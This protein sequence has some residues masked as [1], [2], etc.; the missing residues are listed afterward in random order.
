MTATTGSLLATDLDGTLLRSD[1]TVSARTRQHLD[2]AASAGIDLVFVTGRPIHFLDGIAEAT[3]HNGLVLCANGAMVA[4]LDTLTPLLVRTMA[5]DD[6]RQIATTLADL[7]AQAEFR[8]MMH[9]EGE[10]PLRV[11]DRGKV[12]ERKLHDLLGDGWL[13]YKMAVISGREDDT[14]DEYLAQIVPHVSHLGELTHSSPK[15]PLVE[16]GPRGVHK[17]SALQWYAEERGLS[18]HDV[19]A[20]GDMPNDLPMLRWA[21]HSYAVANAHPQVRDLVDRTLPSNDD[22]GVASLLAELLT[23]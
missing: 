11:V 21:G 19:H 15:Y 6:T 10:A 18:A 23:S 14:S 12:A 8:V 20:V 7:D 13:A 2:E 4:S 5:A 9:R 16:I 22:D 3:G 1:G 17:G